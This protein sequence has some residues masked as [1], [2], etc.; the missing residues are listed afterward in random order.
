MWKTTETGK[1]TTTFKKNSTS[2]LGFRWIE[3]KLI[4]KRPW[5]VLNEFTAYRIRQG[6]RCLQKA[7]HHK[8][9]RHGHG[10]QDSGIGRGGCVFKLGTLNSLNSFTL[11]LLSTL[12]FR[13]SAFFVICV[14][15]ESS[16]FFFQTFNVGRD[17]L[18]IRKPTGLIDQVESS[19]RGTKLSASNLKNRNL[20]QVRPTP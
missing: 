4:K 10:Q 13:N 5:F 14:T 9:I 16:L 12:V 8:Q 7:K 1:K 18:L 11:Q 15:I 3:T 19:K 6:G 20:P 2:L 17:L